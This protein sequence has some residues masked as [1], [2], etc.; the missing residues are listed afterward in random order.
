VNRTP[1]TVSRDDWSLHRKGYQDQLRHQ[2]KVREAI[3]KNLP[4]LISDESIVMSDGKQI[5]KIPIRSLEEYR[6]ATISTSRNT[7]DK[8]TENQKLATFSQEK[9]MAI[10]AKGRM[11][12]RGTSPAWITMKRK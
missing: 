3:K 9:R 7:P 1:F 4:D 10:L 5:V 8:G 2:E 12:A 6:F 11:A